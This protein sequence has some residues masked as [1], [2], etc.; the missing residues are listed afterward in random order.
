Y[1]QGYSTVA[2]GNYTTYGPVPPTPNAIGVGCLGTFFGVN[3]TNAAT[4]FPFGPGINCIFDFVGG[5]HVA[6]A[7]MRQLNAPAGSSTDMVPLN[8]A[9]YNPNIFADGPWCP[10]V[11][12]PHKYDADLMRIRKVRVTLRLQAALASLR[13]P[14]SALFRI[15]GTAVTGDRMV[16]DQEVR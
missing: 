10:S 7:A 6:N 8:D 16:P 2:G 3:C 12:A 9:T 5:V 1:Q 15:G 4:P 14:A 13:G 11:N